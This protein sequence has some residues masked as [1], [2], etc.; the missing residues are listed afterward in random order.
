MMKYWKT[1]TVLILMMFAIQYD[2]NW[3]WAL[4]IFLGLIN[5]FATNEIH[6]VET[7]K[8]KESPLMY[9]IVVLVWVFFT[10]LTILSYLG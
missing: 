5:I 1:I 6:F 9:W 2:W 7:I 10:V 8:K 3:F 4:I